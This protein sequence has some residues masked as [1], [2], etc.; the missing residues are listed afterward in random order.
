MPFKSFRTS[1]ELNNYVYIIYIFIYGAFHFSWMWKGNA[2]TGW[3]WFEK[4]LKTKTI[5]HSFRFAKNLPT[6]SHSKAKCREE[7]TEMRERQQD[8]MKKWMKRGK[9]FCSLLFSTLFCKCSESL[10][11]RTWCNSIWTFFCMCVVPNHNFSSFLLSR[12]RSLSPSL[13]IC[14]SL[15]NLRM[16]EMQFIANLVLWAL[17]S[18]SC[19]LFSRLIFTFFRFK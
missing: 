10:K 9:S 19:C 14:A 12:S 18:L 16:N 13:P 5:K 11:N 2:C 1:M 6:C 7:K 4:L 8:G 15:R 3:E 17:N